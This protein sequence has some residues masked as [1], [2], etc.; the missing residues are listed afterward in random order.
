MY[1]GIGVATQGGLVAPSRTFQTLK[2]LHCHSSEAVKSATYFDEKQLL[3]TGAASGLGKLLALRLGKET[4]ARLILWDIQEGPLEEL[5][6]IIGRH[7]VTIRNVDVGS[8]EQ[9]RDASVELIARQG[10]PDIVI[11]CAGIV[12]G[13]LFTDHTDNDIALTYKVN[14]LGSVCTSRAFLPGMVERGSGQ[15]VF[16][17]S[18]SGYMG[19]R[20]MSV[21]ASSKW[22]VHGF[23]ES[24]RLEL[25]GTG[26]GLTTVIPSFIDTGMFSGAKAP[27]L[28]PMLRP[29]R[30]VSMILDAVVKRRRVVEAPFIVRFVP[31]LKAVLPVSVFDWIAGPVLGVYSSMDSFKGR[32]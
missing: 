12:R 5:A 10:V 16:L 30:V 6:A 29:E 13:K 3:I 14:V 11:L 21:Y 31:F 26:I 27:R 1:V 23:S 4:N 7:R 22:A 9:I 8:Q 20:G 17:G 28:T 15:I 18:A 19:N 25:K 32:S 24:L 2:N